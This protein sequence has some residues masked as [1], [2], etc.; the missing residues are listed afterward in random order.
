M[1]TTI[2]R[3]ECV[4][5]SYEGLLAALATNARSLRRARDLPNTPREHLRHLRARRSLLL[6]VLRANRLEARRMLA[7]CA[8]RL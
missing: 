6:T 2:Q 5:T 1:G 4:Y 7:D 8:I 3:M